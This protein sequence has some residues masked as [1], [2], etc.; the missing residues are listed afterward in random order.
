MKKFTLILTIVVLV[1]LFLSLIPLLFFNKAELNKIAVVKIN[2]VITSDGDGGSFLTG[3]FGVSSS[4]IVKQIKELKDDNSVK[5]VI[6]EINSPGGEVVASQEI[7]EAIKSLNKTKY[8]VIRE[9]GASGGYWAASATDKIFAS[10]VSITGSIGVL[11]SYLEFSKLFEKYGIDYERFVGGKY[12]DLGSAFKD[13]NEEERKL[14]QGK[15]NIIH[16][17]FIEEVS[18]NRKLDK[19]YVKKLATGEFYLGKEA[20]E[21]KLIDEFGN[22]EKAIEEMKKELKLEHA[23]IFE[24]E[25]KVGFLQLLSEFTSYNFGRG[26]ASEIFKLENEN[27][28]KIK[29]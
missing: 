5:G 16:D 1:L 17:Y 22:K 7:G 6:L 23:E 26:F 24:V 9:V 19:E 8:A 14:L 11:G 3:S 10:P 29:I 21:L 12:K 2:G 15:I 20:K 27:R 28:L 18:N 25:R 13:L 4:E